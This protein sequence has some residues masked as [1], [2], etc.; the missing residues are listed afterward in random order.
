M[1]MKICSQCKSQMVE[2]CEVRSVYGIE[3][4]KKHKGLF[5][6]VRSKPL[7]AVCPGCGYVAIYVKNYESYR[8]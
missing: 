4:I 6:S 7:A 1:M 3:I 5:R 2:D 8:N